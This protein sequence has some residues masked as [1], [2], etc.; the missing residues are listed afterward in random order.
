MLTKALCVK[1]ETETN[2]HTHAQENSI[3]NASS[4]RFSLR[5]IKNDLH[6]NF[7]AILVILG[8]DKQG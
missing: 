7:D 3:L 1:E 5:I 8:R 2:T 4:S 6:Y